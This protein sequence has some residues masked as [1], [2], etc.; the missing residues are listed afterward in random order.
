MT[1][2][3]SGLRPGGPVAGMSVDA[4]ERLVLAAGR[5]PCTT[6]PDAWF[7]YEPDPGEYEARQ[8]YEALAAG[9]CRA[10]PV[11]LACLELA[12]AR[13]GSHLGFGVSGGTAPWQRQAIKQARAGRRY[14]A[15]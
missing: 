9:L 3:C 7:P 15:S 14:D 12:I 6:D 4:V 11:S 10:C 8:R 2:S 13:E 5:R 1:T